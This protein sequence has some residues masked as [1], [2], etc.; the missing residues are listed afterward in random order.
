MRNALLAF[1]GSSLAVA[2]FPAGALAVDDPC[3]RLDPVSGQPCRIDRPYVS[4]DV[5]SP[6]PRALAPVEVRATSRGRGIAF[7]W[8]LDGDGGYGDASGAAV[9]TTFA[10]GPHTVGVRATDAFGRTSTEQRAIEARPSDLAP[11]ASILLGS[12]VP[13]YPGVP[14]LPLE[15]SFPLLGNYALQNTDG[16]GCCVVDWDA[17]GDG[18][19]DDGLD[20]FSG[21]VPGPGERTIG[22]RVRQA[23]GAATWVRRTFAIG[24][25]TPYAGFTFGAGILASASI[26]PDGQPLALAWDLDGDGQ[27]DDATG[28]DVRALE[29]AHRVGLAATDPGGDVGVVYGDVTGETPGGRQAPPVTPLLKLNM[30]LAKVKLAPLLARGL[31]V[32]PGC[33]VSCRSTVVIATDKTT[34]KRL[35]L[36]SAQ[37]GMATGEGTTITV[38]LN[39]RARRALRTARSVKVRVAVFATAA[40]GTPGTAN[41]KLTIRR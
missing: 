23:G 17:D 21:F 31:R 29:G 27:F 22:L 37:L 14:E 11:Q 7:S 8:D 41:Q 38:K 10:A 6:S 19:Y 12:R 35:K 24:T 34:A 39:A 3:Y 26:D 20:A 5:T 28:D 15:A 32:T 30:K 40:D 33:P 18:D 25:Q 13:P 4:F 2:A 1:I 9:T 36:R 16:D